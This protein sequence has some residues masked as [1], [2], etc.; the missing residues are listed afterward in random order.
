MW[1]SPPLLA[2][3]CHLPSLLDSPFVGMYVPN[4]PMFSRLLLGGWWPSFSFFLS[5]RDCM[6]LF[7]ASLWW[8]YALCLVSIFKLLV[9]SWGCYGSRPKFFYPLL[10]RCWHYFSFFPS[11]REHRWLFTISPSLWWEYGFMQVYDYH[12]L[13]MPFMGCYGSPPWHLRVEEYNTTKRT[14]L[15]EAL[16]SMNPNLL[17]QIKSKP[18]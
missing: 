15:I 8:E 14:M 16:R 2:R 5:T 4:G 9:P 11:T 6:C 1:R 17:R 10:D 13:I 18:P 7:I 12:F 3:W